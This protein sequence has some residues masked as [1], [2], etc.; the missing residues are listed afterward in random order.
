M[1]ETA[2]RL[3]TAGQKFIARGFS[4]KNHTIRPEDF[5]N[6]IINNAQPHHFLKLAE[7]LSQV[8]STSRENL[9]RKLF[10]KHYTYS[11]SFRYGDQK[12]P[13]VL[14]FEEDSWQRKVARQALSDRNSSVS[15]T[16][17]TIFQ[18]M[19]L[20]PADI[21]QI[22]AMLT[23]KGKDLRKVSIELLLKQRDEVLKACMQRLIASANIDQRLAALEMLTL[24]SERTGWQE[25]VMPVVEQYKTR[26]LNKNEQI[27]LDKLSPETVALK[28][29]F[30]NGFG[31]IDYSNVTA[32]RVPEERFP[33]SVEQKKSLFEKTSVAITKLFNKA[34]GETASLISADRKSVV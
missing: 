5:Y 33:R 24:V 29:G 7:D 19:N 12:Q 8:P 25:F 14:D 4:W 13:E 28:Y 22:E 10:P 30:L 26:K 34:S 18:S 23:R 27:F 3:P 15:A 21:D 16:G 20:Y 31:A 6:S 1:I 32:F 2:S 17:I 9:M 11:W